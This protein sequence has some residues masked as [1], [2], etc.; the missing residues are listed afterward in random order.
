MSLDGGEAQDL[1]HMGGCLV[2]NI[3]TVQPHVMN[4]YLQAI[5]AYNAAGGPVLFDPVGAGATEMRREAVKPLMDGGYFDVI[6]GN[7]TEISV[8]CGALKYQQ[9]GVDSG[10][11]ESTHQEKAALVKKLAK[12]EKNVVI[13]TGEIDYISDGI[14][15]Y[16]VGNGHPYMSRVTGTGCTLGTTIAS[17]TAVEKQDKLLAA[18]AALLVFE[19]A[20]ELACEKPSV[21]GPGTFVPAFIDCLYDISERCERKE[22]GW[23]SKAKVELVAI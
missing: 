6:K 18:L 4:N 23:L 15:T 21:Q 7:E 3:G 12:R 10:K 17:F 5:T 8:L 2:I 13:M 11:S 20:A 1:S 16:A 19:I 14:S 9:R 22:N